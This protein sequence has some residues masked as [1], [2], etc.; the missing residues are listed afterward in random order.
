MG[1]HVFFYKL[2][3]RNKRN[4]NLRHIIHI[5]QPI[6]FNSL[7]LSLHKVESYPVHYFT[8]DGLLGYINYLNPMY[9]S[10]RGIHASKFV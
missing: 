2:H 3:F 1:Q 10:I 5:T 9:I 8:S 6:Q 4:T 7:F